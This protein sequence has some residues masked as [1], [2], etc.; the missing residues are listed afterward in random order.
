MQQ[1]EEKSIH[2]FLNK[3]EATAKNQKKKYL[4]VTDG[5]NFGKNI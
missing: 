1:N 3:M 2:R 5:K 4:Q